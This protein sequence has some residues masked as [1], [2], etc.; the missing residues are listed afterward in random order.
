[1]I[2]RLRSSRLFDLCLL[3]VGLLVGLVF[4]FML[5]TD[6]A[7]A[8]GGG[9]VWIPFLVSAV[10]AGYSLRRMDSWLADPDPQ[11]KPAR[12]VPA[13]YRLPGY[14][15]L[16]LALVLAA[17]VMIRLWPKYTDW[18]GTPGPW[19]MALVLTLLGGYLLADLQK[20][21][22][23][24]AP[25]GKPDSRKDTL[26]IP[27]WLEVLFFLGIAGLAVYLRLH[28]LAEIPA[29][30]YVDETNGA[31]DA[32]YIL[33]G[34]GTS[35][36]A[37]GWYGTPTGYAYYM[38]GLFKFFG[39]GYMTLKAASLIP[40]ILTVL[41][42]YPLGRLMFGKLAG[43][44]AM[45]LLAVSRWHLSM[46]RWGWNETAPPL[47]QILAT[48]FLLRGLRD[49]RGSDFAIAGLVSGLMMYT[50]LSS[51]LALATLGVFAI[52]YL[53]L[54]SGG[55]LQALITH[56]RGLALFLLVFCVAF[57]PLAVTHITDPFTFNNRVQEISIFRDVSASGNLQPLLNNIR[58]HLRFFHQVG[59]HQ[60]KHNL[61][62]EPETDP[63]TGLLFVVGLA[64][65]LTRPR[66]WR[67]W[68]L[69]LW[70]LLG[71]AGGVFS[72][73]HES[74]QSY[75]T[76]TALPGVT[77]LA[78]A[79]L[80]KAG[81]GLAVFLQDAGSMRSKEYA[82]QAGVGLVCIFL[83]ASAIWETSIYF[84]KQ[85]NSIE[86]QSGFNLV[87]NGT[88]REAVAAIEHDMPLYLSPRFY[89]FSPLR[90]M[91]YGAYEEKYHQN[92]LDNRPYTLFRPE[93][94]LPLVNTGRD[95]LILLDTYYQPVLNYFKQL[96]PNAAV[97]ISQW[98]GQM[99]LFI[100][101]QVP[102][103]DIAATQKLSARFTRASG[104]VDERL[105]DEIH[106]TWDGR[107]YVSAE[108]GGLIRMPQSGEYDF[109]SRGGLAVSIDGQAWDGARYLCSGVH[110]ISVTAADA[111]QGEVYLGWDTPAGR[112]EIISAAAFFRLPQDT[113]GLTTYYYNNPAWQGTPVCERNTP[114]LL[115]AWPDQ[116]PLAGP[117][118]AE[119]KGFLRI[120]KAGYYTLRINA[121]DGVRLTLDGTVLAEGLIPNQP[122]DIIAEIDLAEG[123]HPIQIDYFQ[124]GGGSALE[125]YWTP[126][127]GGDSPVPSE[128]LI[129]EQA[130]P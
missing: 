67:Y 130:E 82:R 79:V 121:D 92:T 60:G 118:S 128:A 18:A 112:E 104:R 59:D 26:G 115:L 43:F 45:F 123:D 78:G 46:S 15:C 70:I 23:A 61:P 37:T 87:E 66:D 53:L 68:L 19:A 32:L 14:A 52:L 13:W 16:G 2:S 94:D 24:M 27:V 124:Q 122:N 39:T 125:F 111:R 30:I 17:W 105:V 103:G 5:R 12:M 84:G 51:R 21:P 42:I 77:L 106:E 119:F 6:W 1:M 98:R 34:S 110:T 20:Q 75:R 58:D 108:W 74:P 35:P 63:F 40:A 4:A 86:Y 89:D 81:R 113:Q 107:G 85:A 25:Q 55:P 93:Q 76:L 29:G 8:E 64:Y 44:S 127:G 11:G 95:A 41:A 72:S 48:Y 101:I 62:N 3:A 96:Y 28:R 33:E 99:P 109:T 38:A 114:F 69:W 97:D 49:K 65:G 91:V 22:V 71:L 80:S 9:W 83:A 116:E 129:P 120:E 54:A 50:Y 31:L 56:W 117:F 47:F 88:A 126:P 7:K 100:R 90:F 57:A 102:S 36:F 10:L 73:N